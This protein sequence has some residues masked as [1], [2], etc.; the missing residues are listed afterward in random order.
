MIA[1]IVVT[2]GLAALRERTPGPGIV[3][4]LA[5]A[6][7]YLAAILWVSTVLPSRAAGWRAFLPGAILVAVG[8]QLV[9]LLVVALPRAEAG[10][11]VRA[12]RRPRSR[13]GDPALALP[14]GAALRRRRLPQRVPLGARASRRVAGFI[15]TG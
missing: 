2:A 3:L 6:G 14:R 12:L 11:V 13:H 1:L 5:I 7:L 10:P 8:T 15:L 4:T 9:H